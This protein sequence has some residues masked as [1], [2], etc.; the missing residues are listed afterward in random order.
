MLLFPRKEKHM[1]EN[2]LPRINV[3]WGGGAKYEEGK[4]K[5]GKKEKKEN[6]ET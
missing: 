1:S 2:C 4:Q 5:E 3:V 6:K